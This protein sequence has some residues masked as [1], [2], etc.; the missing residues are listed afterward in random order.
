MTAAEVLAEME[1]RRAPL[2]P[3]AGE[4]LGTRYVRGRLYIFNLDMRLDHIAARRLANAPDDLSEVD[5]DELDLLHRAQ[6]S[7]REWSAARYSDPRF[8]AEI[9]RRKRAATETVRAMLKASV[10][11]LRGAA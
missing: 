1:R 5:D 9:E 11:S 2:F 10:E 6:M 8:L 4:L 7:M 3:D